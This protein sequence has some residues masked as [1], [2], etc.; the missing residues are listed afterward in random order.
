MLV[1]LPAEPF[2][3]GVSMLT[4]VATSGLYG[5]EQQ[6]Y[7]P[8]PPRMSFRT[9]APRAVRQSWVWLSLG[10]ALLLA[11]STDEGVAQ[12]FRIVTEEGGGESLEG[13][14]G[15]GAVVSR[16]RWYA[17]S[18]CVPEDPC[19]I[20]G[21]NIRVEPYDALDPFGRMVIYVR[22]D[23]IAADAYLP[24]DDRCNI[25]YNYSRFITIP[26]WVGDRRSVCA[27]IVAGTCYAC[28]SYAWVEMYSQDIERVGIRSEPTLTVQ[29]PPPCVSPSA[30]PQVTVSASLRG[31]SGLRGRSPFR[32][33]I[34]R[35]LA[36]S[37][38]GTIVAE[39]W[40]S[41][42]GWWYNDSGERTIGGLE[43]ISYAINTAGR[44]PGSV[45]RIRV[46]YGL[47]WEGYRGD[48]YAGRVPLGVWSRDYSVRIVTADLTGD[49]CVNDRDLLRLLLNFGSNLQSFDINCDGV[50][51]DADLI[52]LLSS[53]GQGCSRG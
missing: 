9:A 3:G 51:S 40:S 5:R 48:S 45:I 38:D 14:C 2:A 49:G 6:L 23:W 41:E 50:V 28:S 39:R 29:A 53:F 33:G 44:A 19:P 1:D 8:C 52:I 31:G 18:F 10:I 24:T 12:R 4:R 36:L 32:D 37:V 35:Y 25:R 47:Y 11:C 42:A 46:L 13:G 22:A 7:Q 26:T 15:V 16:C 21:W 20:S 43:D 17:S 30:T 34:R 27:Q